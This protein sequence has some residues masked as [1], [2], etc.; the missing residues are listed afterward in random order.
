MELTQ[1]DKATYPVKL[2][3]KT[4]LHFRYC[5]TLVLKLTLFRFVVILHVLIEEKN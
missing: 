3:K 1:Q 5:Q 4:S 2:K